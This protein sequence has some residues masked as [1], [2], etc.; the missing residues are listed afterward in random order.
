MF[1]IR[2]IS[3]DSRSSCG[4]TTAGSEFQAREL[5]GAPA[6]L[7]GDQLVGAARARA[8]EHRLQDAALLDRLRQ[9]DQRL[10]VEALARLAR[11]RGD[12]LDRQAA[13]LG[14]RLAALGGDR[15][16]EDRGEAAAHPALDAQPRAA[17]SLASSK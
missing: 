1:S 10:L 7:A 6:A 4:A 13:Q 5:R 17:T 12:Q 11:V 14:H 3:S 9:R 15:G 16:R 2:A 8:D